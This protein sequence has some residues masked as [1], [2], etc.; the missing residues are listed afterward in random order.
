MVNSCSSSPTGPTLSS[1]TINVVDYP[2]LATDGASAIV[3]KSGFYPVIVTRVSA[4]VYKTMSAKCTH[5]GCTV[6]LPINN[7]IQ[8]PCHGA[9][10]S[11]TNGDVLRGPAISP[12]QTF[13]NTF[14]SS[15]NELTIKS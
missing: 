6:G 11:A 7:S 2:A 3:T 9:I 14:D 5:E 15:V 13:V 8:C 4:G 10:F 12:L 1:I